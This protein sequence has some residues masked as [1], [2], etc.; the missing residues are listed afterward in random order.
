[1]GSKFEPNFNY[2]TKNVKSQ[3]RHPHRKF[4]EMGQMGSEKHKEKSVIIGTYDVFEEKISDEEEKKE[5][6]L[7]LGVSN[8]GENRHNRPS[9]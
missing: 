8:E 5:K 2:T 1:M 9:Q 7:K 4:E 6:D 3:T